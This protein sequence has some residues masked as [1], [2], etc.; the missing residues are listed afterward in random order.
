MRL[1]AVMLS[2]ALLC[3]CAPVPEGAAI[4]LEPGGDKGDGQGT[5]TTLTSAAPQALFRFTVGGDGRWGVRTVLRLRPSSRFEGFLQTMLETHAPRDQ[6]V[7]IVWMLCTDPQGRTHAQ[8]GLVAA[9]IE[10]G[11]LVYQALSYDA[12]GSWVV[13]ADGTGSTPW[14]VAS[15]PLACTAEVEVDEDLV[16]LSWFES[17][18]VE[19][20]VLTQRR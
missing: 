3:A 13:V 17:L 6:A 18:D 4:A 11:E 10:H 19:V 7:A 9:R 1:V 2:C 8:H 15:G 20:L 12:Q 14:L 16:G 5:L